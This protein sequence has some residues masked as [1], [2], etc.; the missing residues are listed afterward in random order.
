MS[1]AK[2]RGKKSSRWKTF[3]GKRKTFKENFIEVNLILI[4]NLRYYQLAPV[5]IHLNSQ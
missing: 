3:V 5:I 2:V 1:D 4:L